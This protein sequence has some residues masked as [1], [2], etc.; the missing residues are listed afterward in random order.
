M[1][2]H[3]WGRLRLL[4][5]RF[6][7]DRAEELHQRRQ[8]GDFTTNS[9]ALLFYPR[10]RFT[11]SLTWTPNDTWSVNW[12]ADWQTAQDIVQRPRLRRQRRHRVRSSTSTPATSPATTS[13]S[14]TTSATTCRCA[15]AWSTPSTPSRPLARVDAVLELRPLRPSLLHRPELPSV[16]RFGVNPRRKGRLARAALFRWHADVW[17]IGYLRSRL[18]KFVA[19]T[20]PTQRYRVTFS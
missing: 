3:N 14:A 4:A 13:R 11:S 9:A 1:I 19:S 18:T 17:K 12:T 5:A 20:R 16:L 8:P 15:P 7:A 2:G 6:V 10:V